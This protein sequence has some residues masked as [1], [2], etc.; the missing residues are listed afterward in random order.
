MQASKPAPLW[1][2]GGRRGAI[3]ER[4][5][6]PCRR[7]LSQPGDGVV[8]AVRNLEGQH[9]TQ[10]QRVPPHVIQIFDGVFDKELICG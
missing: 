9:Y 7:V 4:M 6:L 1:P 10:T 3:S 5:R 2:R 8:E